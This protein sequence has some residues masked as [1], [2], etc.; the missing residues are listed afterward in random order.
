ML[1]VGVDR[2][3]F[4]A[5][6]IELTAVALQLPF[7]IETTAHEDDLNVLRFRVTQASFLLFKEGGEPESPAF[8]PYAVDL[9][10]MVAADSRF[11]EIPYGKRLPD[12]GV[13]RIYQRR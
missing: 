11:R 6:S 1:L 10:R 3:S 13:A 5:N 9:L 8:N 7:N 4:N 2:G 12:G